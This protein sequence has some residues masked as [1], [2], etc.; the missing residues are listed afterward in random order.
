MEVSQHERKD[1]GAV[2]SLTG[3]GRR[4][5]NCFIRAYPAFMLM[6]LITTGCSGASGPEI[7]AAEQG[8]DAVLAE[9]ADSG[10]SA[11]AD[12]REAE[13]I[14]NACHDIYEKAKET[15][16][17]DSLDVMEQIIKRL[18]E[19]GYAAVDSQNQVDM[20]NAEQVRNFCGA[21]E[22]G[23]AA[24]QT[25]IV[26]DYFG[27][28]TKYDLETEAGEI[29]VARG[30]Y[31]YEN[32]RLKSVNVA[33][34]PAKFWQCTEEG[35]FIFE[36]SYFSED[37]YVLVLSDVKEQAALRVQPLNEEC[38]ELNRRYLLPVGYRGN[39]MFLCDWS[40]GAYGELNFYDL[41]DRCYPLI[42][43]QPLP[44]AME[45]ASGDGAAYLI[46]EDIFEPV[47]MAYCDIDSETLRSHTVYNAED[48][49]YE[50]RPRGFF[51]A[52]RYPDIP[53]PEVAGYEENEDGTITL[54]VNAVYPQE[55]TS[56]AFSHRVVIR[57][58]QNGG[59]QFLSNELLY[60][61]DG[62]E[63]WWHSERLTQ[64]ELER[65]LYPLC[66]LYSPGRQPTSF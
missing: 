26:A 29:T 23:E 58:Y 66:C 7:Q 19:S 46:P 59:F 49:S 33:R 62:Y 34:Y 64:E 21:A 65:I 50:Y 27:G 42:Y 55:N 4:Q 25:I 3:S 13:N 12:M 35:Y 11:Q 45:D 5:R 10:A 20:E 39:N 44:Y 51:D 31:F 1:A 15:D 22:S 30:D 52:G 32:G 53:Y 56:K 6:L 57:P 54:L 36:G 17:L 61:K 24:E 8:S 43:G 38:R 18:G 40:V 48:K 9:E 41:F 2:M 14:A 37:F 28:F 60:P 63:A 16:T 47:I